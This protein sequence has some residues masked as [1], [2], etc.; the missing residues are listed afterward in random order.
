MSK[1]KVGDRVRVYRK[2]YTRTNCSWVDGVMDRAIGNTYTVT[3]VSDKDGDVRLDWEDKP[4]WYFPVEALK[5]VNKSKENKPMG[6]RTFKLVKAMPGIKVG[7]LFQEECEDGTQPYSP[8]ESISGV[9]VRF[10]DRSQVEESSHF[11][12]VFKVHPEYM[13]KDELDKWKAFNGQKKRSRPV[14]STK[15]RKYVKSGKY[16]KKNK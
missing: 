15:K 4:D 6:R 10:S 1:F 14:G 7:T 3:Q 16:A 13:T 5:L 12:E 8:M 2:Y 9:T 11:V